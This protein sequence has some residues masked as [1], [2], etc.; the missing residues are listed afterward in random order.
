MI[1]KAE[2]RP[3]DGVR[4]LFRSVAVGDGHRPA[5]IAL[6]DA[7]DETG[8]PSGVW[9]GRGLAAV[10][11]LAGDVVAERQTEL[12]LGEGRHPDADRIES[13]RL[14]AGDDPAKARRA[15]CWAGRSSTTAP[16]RPRTPRSGGAG[17]AWTWCSGRRR[18]RT[19]RG[20]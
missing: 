18:R 6:G 5:G 3:G 19:S 11:L 16:R 4:Y 12:L 10:G 15:T 8:V 2:L 7:Q 1:S 20:R 17:W 13:E 14:E 9:Q